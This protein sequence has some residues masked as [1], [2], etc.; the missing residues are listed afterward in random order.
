MLDLKKRELSLAKKLYISAGA[1]RIAGPDNM[2]ILCE[3][4]CVCVR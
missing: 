4:V 3:F 1:A 2:L